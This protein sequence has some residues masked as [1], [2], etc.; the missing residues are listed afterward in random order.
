MTT[1]RSSFAAHEREDAASRAARTIERDIRRHAER[2][3]VAV[4]A[5]SLAT[6]GTLLLVG[7]LSVAIAHGGRSAETESSSA[8]AAVPASVQPPVVTKS[9][10]AASNASP[11]DKAAPDAASKPSKPAAP[12]P[13]AAPAKKSTKTAPTAAK[14]PV[15]PK[16]KS[17]S[18]IV[19]R[20]CGRCHSEAQVSSGLDLESAT[21]SV[22]GMIAGKYITL[23]P[24]ERAAV[25][26]ALTKK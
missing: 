19:A 20:T 17:Q 4:L 23:T 25:I 12:A 24:S 15:K 18:G 11:V 14:K 13:S 3:R 5:V 26:A 6:A 22:D 7:G 2:R 9:Q 16:P 1:R 21:S 8:P 10:P